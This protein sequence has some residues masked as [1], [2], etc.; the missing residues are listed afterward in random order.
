MSARDIDRGMDRFLRALDDLE[1]PRVMTVGVHEDIGLQDHPGESDA[2]VVEVAQFLEFGTIHEAPKSFVRS[3]MDEIDGAALMRTAA[4]RALR[5]A[6]YGSSESGHADRAFA[7][8]GERLARAMRRKIP[9][10][11]GATREAIAV[12]INGRTLPT[13]ASVLEGV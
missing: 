9:I 10:E 2:N 4:E 1:T 6:M 7:R 13:E 3:T 11:T 8:V 5:S 12:K